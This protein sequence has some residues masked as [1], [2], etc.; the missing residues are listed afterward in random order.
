MKRV[1]SGVLVIFM[2]M[3]F[4]GCGCKHKWKD[5]T[6]LSIKTCELCD[7]TEG[8]IGEHIFADATCYTPKTCEVCDLQE[9]EPLGHDYTAATMEAPKTCNRCGYTDGEKL[10]LSDS[11][12]KVLALGYDAEDN[13]Y[14]LVAN[15]KEDYRGTTIEIGVIKNN[16]WLIDLS[17]NSP[18]VD[19]TGLLKGAGGNFKGSI[20]E[21]EFAK[22]YYVG[23][24]C[25]A[26]KGIIMNSIINK[27]YY[28]DDNNEYYPEIFLS[29]GTVKQISNDA[30]F[31]LLPTKESANYKL[32]DA[33]TM[34]ITDI[35]LNCVVNR[36]FNVNYDVA[37]AYSEGLFAVVQY[38]ENDS[39]KNGFYDINGK[40]V[41][42][43]S[44]YVLSDVYMAGL[45]FGDDR[46]VFQDGTCSFCIM[47]DQGTEFRIMIDKTGNVINS[48]KIE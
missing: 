22:F 19:G 34:S 46:L 39:S 13:Y 38:R 43:L 37:Y 32:L 25:F 5:A 8:N 24:G 27:S 3:S 29:W 7:K 10:K 40:K 23:A 47:N 36:G 16:E 33:N 17:S 12:D 11:C 21:E 2:L 48:T 41:I 31:L 6:C 20:Y 45:A 44:Q 1:I 15:E 14:E 4:V 18:F 9:G 35:N 30:L 42:D 26:Y 28:P